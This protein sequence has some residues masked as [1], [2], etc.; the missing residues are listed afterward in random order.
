MTVM[1]M[2]DA[3][4]AEVARLRAERAKLAAA[5]ETAQEQLRS[6]LNEPPTAKTVRAKPAKSP[7]EKPRPRRMR[8]ALGKTLAQLRTAARRELT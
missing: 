2:L 8:R 6:L 3:L 1:E 5:L 4:E 7:D